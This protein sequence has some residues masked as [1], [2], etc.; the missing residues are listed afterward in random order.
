M[1]ELSRRFFLGTASLAASAAGE[2]ERPARPR[3]TNRGKGRKE[4]P[5]SCRLSGSPWN[6]T[7]DA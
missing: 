4:N 5:M 6:R 7:R 3:K 1:S 2:G